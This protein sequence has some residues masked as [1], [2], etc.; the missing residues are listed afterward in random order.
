MATLLKTPLLHRMLL[1]GCFLNNI[2]NTRFQ[3]N[4]NYA[5]ELLELFTLGVDNG[6]TQVDI[7]NVARA[8]SGWNG[9]DQ[10]NLC[11]DV[12]FIQP[13][14]DPGQKTIFG[15]TGNWGYDDVINLLFTERAVQISEYICRK[16][17]VDF[18]NPDVNE[19]MV[20]LLA[21]VFR[22][23]NF[24]IAPVMKAL[25]QSEHFFDDAN[26]GTIIPGHIAYF[27]TF[28]KP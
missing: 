7:T 10:T 3:P 12:T 5:R 4:E 23:N 17:Y 19:D 1:I 25:L 26:V 21:K 28:L 13:F 14:W 24:E 6:Y 9:I 8:I 16:L 22:D 27:L 18:V 20:K 15:K 2:Q 11:G